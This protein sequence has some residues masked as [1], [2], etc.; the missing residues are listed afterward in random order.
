MEILYTKRFQKHYKKLDT[1][2]QSKVKTTIE[3]FRDDP[4]DQ[5]LRNH[6]LEGEYIWYR[7]IDVTW[8]FRIVFEELS[9]D[10]Y[11]LVELIDVGTHSQLYG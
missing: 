8:D 4:W 6:P 9:E 10:S 7:S 11:A 5:K 1:Y 2:I 3:I